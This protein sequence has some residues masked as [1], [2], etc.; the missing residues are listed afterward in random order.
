MLHTLVT[1]L[2]GLPPVAVAV[3]ICAA[4]AYVAAGRWAWS[5]LPDAGLLALYLWRPSWGMLSFV[6]LVG[7]VRHLP[8]WARELASMFRLDEYEG[9]TH[10]LV[11]FLLPALL[12]REHM[13]SASGGAHLIGGTPVVH[14]P[15]PRTGTA[16]PRETL[17]PPDTTAENADTNGW[18]MP[19]ISTRLSDEEMITM[20]ATQKGAHGGHKYSANK[21]YDLVGGSRADVL[22]RV[23]AIREGTSTV[24][25]PLT[26]AQQQT[27]EDL[28]LP[29]HGRAP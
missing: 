3:F 29:T 7:S 21:I 28:G 18:E 2:A 13:S 1:T 8:A 25:R 6:L 9:W 17:V 23:K 4:Y 12:T 15:V 20:L 26:E 16:A 19:R 14:V 22:G 24:Y 11:V 27:R 10:A 5:M